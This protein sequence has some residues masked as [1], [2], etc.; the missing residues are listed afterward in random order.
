MSGCPRTCNDGVTL[1]TGAFRIGI[2][3][4]LIHPVVWAGSSLRDSSHL[5]V[6]L[7]KLPLM[8]ANLD[9][10][11]D[12]ALALVPQER[13]AL[14]LAL[15]DSLDGDDEVSVARAWADEI[16]QRKEDLGAGAA[17]AAPWNEVRARLLAL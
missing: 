2:W 11:I 10:V 5:L 6:D 12:E 17:V 1:V 15:L 3:P 14:V 4:L 13:S 7:G 9:H 8:N 16:R